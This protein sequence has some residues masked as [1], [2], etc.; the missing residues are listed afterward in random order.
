MKLRHLRSAAVLGAGGIG[1]AQAAT[2]VP[3]DPMA[4]PRIDQRQANQQ[5]RIDL[6]IA[7]GS[8]TQKEADRLKAEQARN[9]RAEEKAR[10]D[11]VETKKERV[12][13]NLK[14]NRSS[15]HIARQKHDRQEVAP[16]S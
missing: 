10:A 12:R 13:L 5:K 11:G 1:F 8:L 7:S 15:K 6:G 14:E 2:T 3:A 9:A 16:G 4:T